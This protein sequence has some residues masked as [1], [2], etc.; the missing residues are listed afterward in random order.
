MGS[1]GVVRGQVV[2]MLAADT[3]T[4]SRITVAHV[5]TIMA[6]CLSLRSP[7][8][9]RSAA[10]LSSQFQVPNAACFRLFQEWGCGLVGIAA[11]STIALQLVHNITPQKN[12]LAFDVWRWRLVCGV[13]SYGWQVLVKSVCGVA[14]EDAGGERGETRGAL[15][16]SC[17][18]P[19]VGFAPHPC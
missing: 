8:E 3:V 14:G 10:P 2:S 12:L 1:S 15:S 18:S 16:L 13:E 4:Q 7:A 11:S 6:S 17:G 19:E 5:E 9:Y